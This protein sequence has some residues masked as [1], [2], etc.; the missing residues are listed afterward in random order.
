M[1]MKTLLPS[2]DPVVRPRSLG[3]RACETRR[4]TVHS[5]AVPG[6]RPRGHAESDVG[7]RG[8]GS[9]RWLEVGQRAASRASLPDLGQ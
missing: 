6:R 2:Q 8:A 4:S 7:E 9:A 5:Q 3:E 1:R